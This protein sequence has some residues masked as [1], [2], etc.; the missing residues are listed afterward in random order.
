M[1]IE[2]DF[3]SFKQSIMK[4]SKDNSKNSLVLSYED[5]YEKIINDEEF[6]KK[7]SSEIDDRLNDRKNAKAVIKNKE[8]FRELKKNY[9]F[10]ITEIVIKNN[11]VV[12]G[13]A[14]RT[15]LISDFVEDMVGFSAIKD[16]MYDDNVT[17]IYILKYNKIY[18]ES[19]KHSKPVKF[20][21]KFKNEKAFKD[22]AERLLREA[23]KG[24]LDNGE[25]KVI[26]F[27]LYG[28]RYNAIS[29]AVSPNGI[30]LTIRKHSED[31]ITLK[32]IIDSGCMTQ[33]VADFLGKLILGETNMI[34][35]GITGSGKTT[36]MRALLDY[37][38]TMSNKR[39]L[40]CEDTRE[41]F[42]TNDHTLELVTSIGD[43]E[44]S[45]IGLRDVIILA[46]RQKPRYIIVGEVRGPEAESAVEA[47]STGHSTIFTMHAG[48]PINAIDRLVTKYLMQ[49]PNLGIDVVER[50]IGS[51]VDY[52]VIQD[53]IPG[54]GRRITSITEV[55]YDYDTRRV[56]L[57]PIVKFNI[58]KNKFEFVN[59]ISL[60][61]AENML[62]KGVKD[63][64]L[65]QYVK[66]WQKEELED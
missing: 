31:H 44:K 51:S 1:A 4:Y 57:K 30:T 23:N 50:I 39:M 54:V 16:L 49:M 10:I 15:K 20:K 63:T 5:A 59:Y 35:A 29:P 47:A 8:Y 13:Y 58:R 2:Q 14:D 32:Q 24:V 28:D 40:V 62:R 19:R 52:I 42:P 41:L 48:K 60:D 53:D 56:S 3:K 34:V 55:E 46:L 22:F 37:Y 7:I 18:Y 11:I 6:K 21:G 12:R 25:N 38:V 27:D 43:N 36:T 17:D 9:N 64:E 45:S 65:K 66:E 61:K 26:D 33:E